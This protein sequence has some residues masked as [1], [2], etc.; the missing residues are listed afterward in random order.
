MTE[1]EGLSVNE[2]GKNEAILTITNP[3][4]RFSASGFDVNRDLI[5]DA[6]ATPFA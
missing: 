3:V 2:M 5:I 1:L 6:D 4:F